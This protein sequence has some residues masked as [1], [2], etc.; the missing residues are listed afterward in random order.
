MDEHFS[1]GVTVKLYHSKL[2]DKVKSTTVGFDAGAYF[3]ITDAIS[4]G[5]TIQDINSKYKWDT[6]PIYDE[7][8]KTTDDKFP[9]LRRAAVSYRLPSNIGIISWEF[10]NSSEKTNLMRVGA[11]YTPMEY[12]SIRGGLDRWDFSNNATGAKPSFGFS[13]KKPFNGW[14]PVVTY[15]FIIEPFASHGMHVVTLSGRF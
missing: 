7:G 10:E 14:T 6:K 11:E 5:I 2:F 8:G 12:F 9:N 15:A 4:A 3:Q 1:L 13:V